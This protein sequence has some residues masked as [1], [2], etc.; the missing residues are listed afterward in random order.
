VPVPPALA[1]GGPTVAVPLVV[2]AE[3]APTVAVPLAALAGGG[4]T[5]PGRP[6]VAPT[7]RVRPRAEP[8]DRRRKPARAAQDAARAAGQVA[9]PTPDDAAARRPT[10]HRQAHRS[11]GRRA[12]P[13]RTASDPARPARCWTPA[14]AEHGWPAGGRTSR[15]PPPA[16]PANVG[17]RPGQAR[18]VGSR[19]VGGRT[20]CRPTGAVPHPGRLLL[21]T[22]DGQATALRSATPVRPATRD[23]PAAPAGRDGRH[24]RWGSDRIS[25]RRC[26]WQRLPRVRFR[27]MHGADGV[28]GC[29]SRPLVTGP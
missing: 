13:D 15:P 2:L 4:P 24:H 26:R 8:T 1:E 7:P 22:L 14:R 18:P 12:R 19:P 27:S 16:V 3:A 21:S 23:L 11:R 6:A 17:T 29:S 25:A 20:V 10:G 28:R 5:V 9:G